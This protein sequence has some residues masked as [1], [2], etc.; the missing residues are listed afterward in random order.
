MRFLGAGRGSGGESD[1][2]F[3]GGRRECSRGRDSS[4]SQILSGGDGS[5]RDPQESRFCEGLRGIR[6]GWGT[7]SFVRDGAAE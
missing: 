5:A 4:G 7:V 2:S 6:R 1:G 3:G